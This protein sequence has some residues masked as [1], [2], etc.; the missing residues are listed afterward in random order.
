MAAVFFSCGVVLSLL[1]ALRRY[2]PYF[3]SE[4]AKLPRLVV[5]I[6]DN[7]SETRIRSTQ[8]YNPLAAL[9]ITQRHH[10]QNSNT[11]NQCSNGIPDTN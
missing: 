5:L 9:I 3:F 7:A 4:K 1:R 8:L 2:L 11:K 6:G 10:A